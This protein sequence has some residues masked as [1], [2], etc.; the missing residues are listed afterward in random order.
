ME[1]IN[2]SAK[3]I[4]Q[5]HENAAIYRSMVHDINDIFSRIIKKNHFRISNYAVRIKTEDS[6]K[7]KIE[8][9]NKYHDINDITDV[10]AARVILL[11]EDDV[12]RFYEA[13]KE[14]FEIVEYCDRRKKNQEDR[15]DYGY[16]SLH[17]LVKFTDERCRMIE[18]SDYKNLVFEV[19][20]RTTL[21]HSWAEIEHGLGY[22]SQYEIPRNIRRRLTR[23][24]A[25]L[26]LCDEEFVS[27]S[28]AVDAYNEGLVHEEK[29]LKTDINKNSLI[30]YVTD[31]PVLKDL[32][33]HA[34]EDYGVKLDIDDNLI[35]QTKLIHRMHYMG[36]TYINELDE[37]V[38]KNIHSI[39]WIFHQHLSTFHEGDSFN[40][41]YLLVWISMIMLVEQGINDPEEIF[42]R[43]VVDKVRDLATKVINEQESGGE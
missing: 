36:Y 18:Y 37:F 21:Q 14:N 4:D 22:K 20:I 11:F 43:E 19:Q 23:L 30:H 7:R 1:F 6:L 31:T 40:P 38:H 24:A 42:N 3:I 33:E 15:I 2:Y 13:I 26:E 5:Y 16:N 25:T 41:L 35:T 17:L 8:F 27:I 10:V 32:L 9:K 28:N 39:Q 29:V 34:K 12:D